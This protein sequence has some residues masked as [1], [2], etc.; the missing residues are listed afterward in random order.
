VTDLA[1]GPQIASPATFDHG[2]GGPAKRHLDVAWMSFWC[3][4]VSFGVVLMSFWCRL[5]SY[6]CR[7]TEQAEGTEQAV[8]A[9]RTLSAPNLPKA[10]QSAPKRTKAHQAT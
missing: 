1:Q 7:G 5:M 4:L 2:L 3:R 9:M 8:D 6:G 10:H